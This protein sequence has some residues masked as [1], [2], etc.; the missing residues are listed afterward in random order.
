MWHRPCAVAAS[1]SWPLSGVV[2]GCEASWL[3]AGRQ[4]AVWAHTPG[5]QF[6]LSPSQA[7]EWGQS[8]GLQGP[9]G[10]C[11]QHQH[12]V[13]AP[14]QGTVPAVQLPVQPVPAAYAPAETACSGLKLAELLAGRSIHSWQL[15]GLAQLSLSWHLLSPLT[16]FMQQACQSRLP[17]CSSQH[18][19]HCQGGGSTIETCAGGIPRHC[20]TLS[21]EQ[22]SAAE[23]AFAD[24]FSLQAFMH[25]QHLPATRYLLQ[26]STAPVP[27]R[28]ADAGAAPGPGVPL[29]HQPC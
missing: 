25:S 20:K 12:P 6:D 13:A 23:V 5:R 22:D 11:L 4:H 27:C 8:P 15:P 18:A 24:M 29:N 3:A 1:V 9:A 21:V 28:H 2:L 17:C 10:G 7:Q 16:S 26:C 19:C 14:D